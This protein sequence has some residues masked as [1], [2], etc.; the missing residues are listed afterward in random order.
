MVETK[1]EDNKVR[2]FLGDE[3]V[4]EKEAVSEITI[5]TY[6]VLEDVEVEK[7]DYDTAF[8]GKGASL[9][10]TTVNSDGLVYVD[11][12]GK[13]G[14]LSVDGGTVSGAPLC[15][16]FSRWYGG[17]ICLTAT[18]L[19]EDANGAILLTGGTFSGCSA[20]ELNNYAG[21]GGAIETWGGVFSVQDALFTNSASFTENVPPQVS[22]APPVPA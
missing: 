7:K 21:T 18:G 6:T 14:L 5:G 19:G 16:N 9:T 15:E 13:L 20:I 17:A 3:C 22:M 10:D 8:V 11:D 4:L 1:F 2:L 12:G